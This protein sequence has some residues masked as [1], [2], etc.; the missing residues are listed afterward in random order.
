MW[1]RCS[2]VSFK[3]TS[4][5]ISAFKRYYRYLSCKPVYIFSVRSIMKQI[6]YDMNMYSMTFYWWYWR[7]KIWIWRIDSNHTI[8]SHMN[9]LRSAIKQH[10]HYTIQC[11]YFK[12]HC[13]NYCYFSKRHIVYFTTKLCVRLQLMISLN[14]RDL[15]TVNVYQLTTI[16]SI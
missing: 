12:L 11:C 14:L 7:I 10:E 1:I 16:L 6:Y 3:I 15:A 13:E 8:Y 4:A 5:A 9:I 2:K